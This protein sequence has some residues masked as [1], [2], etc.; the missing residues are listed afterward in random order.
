MKAPPQTLADWRASLIFAISPGRDVTDV[1]TSPKHPGSSDLAGHGAKRLTTRQPKNELLEC[2]W[3]GSVRWPAK[4]FKDP[5]YGNQRM[6]N[7][8]G[9]W[10]YIN[11]MKFCNV[12]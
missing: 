6:R 8:N 4:T 7:W 9:F 3:V 11:R 10:C 5:V 12:V 2:T 1:I